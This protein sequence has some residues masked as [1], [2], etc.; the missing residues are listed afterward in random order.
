MRTQGGAA[1]VRSVDL[2]ENMLNCAREMTAETG[3]QDGTVVFERWDLDDLEAQRQLLPDSDNDTY[4]VVFSTLAVH[5]L[6]HL[7]ELVR[8]I[9]RVLKPGGHFVFSAE[10]PILTA[11]S[12][13]GIVKIPNPKFNAGS[14]NS[15]LGGKQGEQ[16]TRNIWPVNNYFHEGLRVTDWL[17]P[18][19]RKYHRTMTTYV[20]ILLGAG[21]ELKALD[22]W[23][24]NEEEL[25]GA[26]S[27][28]KDFPNTWVKPDFLLMA[29]RK[30]A[31]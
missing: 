28:V 6:E 3:I 8:H 22:E 30:R 15:S 27:W 19:V 24:P 13:P 14:A 4:D 21:F 18:G 9:H 10:H 29:G 25:E 5:Y 2:S 1:F 23:C 17:A 31:A 16:E 26:L 12:A 7:P 11:P 20:N